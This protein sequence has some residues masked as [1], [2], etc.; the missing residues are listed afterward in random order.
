MKMG[1]NY[2]GDVGYGNAGYKIS[3]GGT[4]KHIFAAKLGVD[5]GGLLTVPR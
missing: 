3:L 1:I 5:I 4:N 2:V